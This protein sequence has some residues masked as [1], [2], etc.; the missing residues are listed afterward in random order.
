MSS[1][2]LLVHLRLHPALLVVLEVRLAS[3]LGEEKEGTSSE[4]DMK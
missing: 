1:D 4:E 3:L 2:W